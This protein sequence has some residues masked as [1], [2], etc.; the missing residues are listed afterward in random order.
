MSMTLE[1]V[2]N[3][4]T[5]DEVFWEDPDE[6]ECS[7]HITIQTIEVLGDDVVRIVG[8]DG[9]ELECFRSELR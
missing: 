2:M 6:G 8:K 1:E 5:G 7:R 9:S 4:H 3:L